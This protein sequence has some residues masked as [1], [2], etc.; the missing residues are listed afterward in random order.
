MRCAYILTFA[1][2]MKKFT[3]MI[4]DMEESFLTWETWDSVRKKI[5]Q[6]NTGHAR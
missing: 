6:S 3:V 5:R 4:A 1:V 2:P